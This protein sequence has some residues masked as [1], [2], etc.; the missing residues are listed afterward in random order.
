M[1]GQG[2]AAEAQPLSA[3]EVQEQTRFDQLLDAAETDS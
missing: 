1:N 2:S 3:Q